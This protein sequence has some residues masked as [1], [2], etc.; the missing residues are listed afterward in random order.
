MERAGDPMSV[1]TVEHQL[2]KELRIAFIPLGALLAG[3][4][5]I[6]DWAPSWIET[7]R[8]VAK[9]MT[10]RLLAG[11]RG[12]VTRV[13]AALWPRV[14]PEAWSPA[15]WRSPL[16]VVIARMAHDPDSPLSRPDRSVT[17]HQAADMLGISRGTIPSYVERGSLERDD[18]TG[19]ILRS[20]VLKRI[21]NVLPHPDCGPPPPVNNNQE[22]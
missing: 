11:D 16:G 10:P 8:E 19:S 2:T 4:A 9:Q 12:A 7:S 21:A 1:E 20:S 13:M 5:P 17:W 22:G 14:Q 6:S 15:W 3:D 18:A